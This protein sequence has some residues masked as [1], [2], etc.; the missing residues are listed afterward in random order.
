MRRW[1]SA[2]LLILAA[3]APAAPRTLP[4]AVNGPQPGIG[5]P[6]LTADEVKN[7]EVALATL[8]GD[9]PIKYQLAD[10][11]FQKG[12]DPAGASLVSIKL[13]EPMA[14]GDLNGDGAGDA[15][16][17]VAENYGGTGTFVSL[18]AFINANGKPVQAGIAAIDDRP[19]IGSLAI[20][21]GLIGLEATVHRFEDPM[22]C[23]TL[24]TRRHYAL[25]E[26]RL[27]QRDFASQSESGAWRIIAITSPAD[28]AQQGQ[29]LKIQGTVTIAPFENNLSYHIM[30]A[31]GNELGAGPVPVAAGEIGGPGTFDVEVPLST[32]PAGTKVWVEIRDQSPADGSV[33]AMDSVVVQR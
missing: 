19:L 21:A 1:V 9:A 22:C 15:A 8:T 30:D 7:A 16:A 6:P 13:V 32:V 31:A 33:L 25:G 26:G 11:A 28:G 4:T 29:S 18:V 23:P 3:C 2:L 27:V 5:T 10:G 12:T 17:L 20:E 14:F 24:P